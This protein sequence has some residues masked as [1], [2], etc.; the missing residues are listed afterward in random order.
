MTP[1]EIKAA[2]GA[3][4]LSFPVTHF[5]SDNRFDEGPYRQHCAW[6][7]EKP[8]AG[9]FAAGG[10]GE[11]FSLSLTEVRD[12]PG[13]NYMA[14]QGVFDVSKDGSHYATMTPAKRRY[15]QPPMPTTEAA[16]TGTLLGDLYAVIGEKDASGGYA[17]RLYFNPL[18][19]WMWVGALIMVVGGLVSLSDRRH[20]IGVPVR[21]RD[22]ATQPAKA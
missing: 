20:R 19:P 4:L 17:T 5:D 2:L 3:G 12:V 22:A 16:I 8:L 7:L 13:A 18:V 14:T 1:Q 21:A 10:T 11:F 15:R 6:M 9:L